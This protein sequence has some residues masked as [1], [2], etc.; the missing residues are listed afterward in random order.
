METTSGRSMAAINEFLSVAV[1][2]VWGLPLVIL[3]TGSGLLFSILLKGI[4]FKG[5]LHAIKIV[6]GHYDHKEDPGEVTHFQALSAALSGTVGL[7]N[8]AGVAIA[9][10]AGGP[11]ATFWMILIGFLGMATKYAE[12]TLGVMYRKI[13]ENGKVLGGPMQ[14]IVNGLGPSWRFLA[15]FFSIACAITAFGIGNLF[16]V[17]YMAQSLNAS[18]SIP[19]ILTGIILAI[20]VGTVILGGIKRIALIA[21]Y[22]VPFMGIIY[23]SAC[24]IVISMNIFEVPQIFAQMISGA[25]TGTA[26]TGG[27]MGVVV[28]EVIKQ[29]ARRACFS[30]EAGLGAA[31]I[32]HAAASTKEPV[33]E[34]LVALLEPFIDT[35]VI[36]TMTALVILISGAW[37]STSN[38]QGAELTS[39]AFNSSLPGFGTFV[40]PIIITLFAYSTTLTYAYYGETAT[41]FLFENQKHKEFYVT[42]YKILFCLIIILGSVW[43]SDGVINFSDMMMGLMVVPNLIAVW[44]LFPKLQK[45]TN[46]YFKRLNNNEFSS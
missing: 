14:Y 16:Q 5:F 4:Q 43:S 24:L 11:G 32:A 44:L 3:L 37:M 2:Y 46:D 31:A 35:I 19:Q 34:G 13:D 17:H 45:A 33:R 8:I 30:N 25:F 27:F 40:L 29:G 7:G 18:F 41:K 36:C 38:V 20:T 1:G 21:S 22:L 23:I 28:A 10:K 42:G 9:I 26:A 15:I 39:I 12:C 6:L